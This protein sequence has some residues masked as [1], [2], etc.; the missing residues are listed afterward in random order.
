MNNLKNN[1][2]D[3]RP[4]EIIDQTISVTFR[5]CEYENDELAQFRIECQ[6]SELTY[7]LPK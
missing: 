5:V 7:P 2:L 3:P 6:V 1:N 4:P